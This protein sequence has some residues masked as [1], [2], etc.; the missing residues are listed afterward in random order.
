[1]SPD[2]TMAMSLHSRLPLGSCD[3]WWRSWTYKVLP[4]P[5]SSPP[6]HM[7]GSMCPDMFL[8][9]RTDVR[10]DI[11][12]LVDGRAARVGTVGKL[13]LFIPVRSSLVRPRGRVTRVPSE[14]Q[15]RVDH[16]ARGAI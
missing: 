12:M 2:A 3:V 16:G 11:V 8:S 7:L 14:P 6:P 4:T 5:I 1:M 15:H 9:R 13:L 10:K